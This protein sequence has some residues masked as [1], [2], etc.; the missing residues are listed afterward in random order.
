MPAHLETYVVIAVVAVVVVYRQ[1]RPQ[2]LS[3]GRYWLMPALLVVLSVLAIFGSRGQVGLTVLAVVIGCIL[4]I[5]LGIV[6]GRA[7]K[8][9]LGTKPRTIVIAPTVFTAVLW[10]VAFAFKYAIRYVIGMRAHAVPVAF[11][12]GFLIFAVATVIAS[13]VVVYL[14]YRRLGPQ[15][16]TPAV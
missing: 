8:M 16:A 4:G 15:A 2:T 7:T 14:R 1:L 3:L 10:I 11:S 6:R 5:P 12:D 13:R 9:R